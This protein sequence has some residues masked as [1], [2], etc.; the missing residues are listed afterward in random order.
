MTRVDSSA[1]EVLVFTFKEGLLSTVAHDLQLKVSRAT[2]D[3]EPGRVVVEL[4]AT[5][6]RVVGAMRQGTVEPLM[7][8]MT[9]EIERNIIADVLEPRR[10]GSV[11]FESTKLTSAV[12]E[13][14]LSLHG[15]TRPVR[16]AVQ[17]VGT[18]RVAEVRLDQ[19]EFGIRPYSA[20]LGTLKVKPEV[21]VR[22]SIDVSASPLA[23]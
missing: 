14:Q 2:L 11:R 7:S 18:R 6:L 3:L 1:F 15:V 10:F 17:T 4:D 21:L 13:G 19:R 8:A 16:G 9:S 20:M 23:E 22:V 5:S 12:L